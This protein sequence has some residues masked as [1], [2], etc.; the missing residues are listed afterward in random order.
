MENNENYKK[1]SDFIKD[2]AEKLN[3]DIE[4]DVEE[5]EDG[6]FF[7]ITGKDSA[8]LIGY[9]GECLDALQTMATMLVEDE[10]KR[11]YVDAENYREKRKQTLI[12]LAERLAQKAYKTR[13]RQ[14]L[15]PMNPYERRIIHFALA[16]SEYAETVSEG[17]GKNRHIVIIPKNY[18]EKEES[19]EI[20]YGKSDFSQKGFGKTRTF[21]DKKRRF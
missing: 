13:R 3:C 12:A 9:R 16:E 7:T 20:K 11:I 17:E 19:V 4:L 5:K 1:I 6:V 21:G 18:V 14:S 8:K 15:E 2:I 10:E